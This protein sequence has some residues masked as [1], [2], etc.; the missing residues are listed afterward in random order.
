MSL[1][2][3]RVK[4]VMSD[5]PQA[6]KPLAI[7][8]RRLHT[9]TPVTPQAFVKFGANNYGFV[10]NISESGLVFAP[11]GT[12]TLAV[13]A[14]A[15]MRFQLP[16]SKE[17][18]ETNGEVVWIAESQREAGVHFVDLMD[19][20]RAKIRDW[21][22]QEPV[23]P[24]LPDARDAI[25][26]ALAGSQPST[27][28]AVPEED[29]VLKSIFADPGLFLVGS[30]STRSKHAL[31]QEPIVAEEPPQAPS[32]VS[33]PERRSHPR[34]RVLSLEYLDLG[35][36]NGGIVLNLGEDGMYIQAVASLSPDHISNLSFRIPESDYEIETSGNIVWVGESKKD[37]GI[38]FD[39]L[40]EEARLKIREWVAAEFPSRQD[41]RQSPADSDQFTAKPDS[42][43]RKRDRLVEMPA[44]AKLKS[45][46]HASGTPTVQPADQKP[47]FAPE[48][49]AAELA[50]LSALDAAGISVDYAS[51]KQPDSVASSPTPIVAS[52]VVQKPVDISADSVR[53]KQTDLSEKSSDGSANAVPSVIQK[54]FDV[55]LSA[56]AIQKPST[57]APP[58]AN[59][60]RPG[61]GEKKIVAPAALTSATQ[62]QNS[63]AT[64][65]APLNTPPS[66][67]ANVPARQDDRK[68]ASREESAASSD[69]QN[70]PA[71]KRVPPNVSPDRDAVTGQNN[72]KSA[73]RGISAAASDLANWQDAESPAL[74]VPPDRRDN[75]KGVAQGARKQGAAA[76]G[77]ATRTNSLTPT[78]ESSVV[79]QPR[80]WKSLAAG[81]V[82]I[83]LLSFAAGWIAAGPA[84]RK[85]IFDKFVSRQTD[86]SQSTGNPGSSSAQTD[87]PAPGASLPQSN[88]A[89]APEQTTNPAATQPAPQ[90]P[91]NIATQPISHADTLS[92]TP[93]SQIPH[94]TSVPSQPASQ[95]SPPSAAS[96]GNVASSAPEKS[97]AAKR[98][99]VTSSSTV[100]NATNS[101]K[102]PSVAANNTAT[103]ATPSATNSSLSNAATS[104][105]KSSLAANN[106]APPNTVS[107]ESNATQP[108]S[109]SSSPASSLPSRSSTGQPQPAQL[110]AVPSAPSSPV[111]KSAPP[112]VTTSTT[113]PTP[114]A[115]AEVVKATVSVNAS[116]FPSIRVPPEL[117]SQISKQGASLQIGQLISRVDPT[118][119]EDAQ[120][121][122][123]EG[124]VKLRAIIARD[125]SIQDID[126]M[127]GPPLLVA[128]AANAV[129]Q[130][131]YK[132]TSLDGQPVEATESITVAF[133]LQSVR[134]N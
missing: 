92:P 90:A 71:A 24:D 58:E 104:S 118:Y 87:A 20:T 124:V 60:A 5:H 132:P 47:D 65:P 9:R 63:P 113:S 59:V 117:K 101:P 15:K 13:G 119:P 3:A 78:V 49:P 46:P 34:R 4:E 33:V 45:P 77:I 35:D 30:K 121:Q 102:L 127:S 115:A 48:L 68:S 131:R 22:S 82:V 75:R 134:A 67:A 96:A 1:V 53:S 11:T 12:L 70:R 114:T 129:R 6:E 85:Q 25:R 57:V 91:A 100:P 74:T 56:P 36:S 107:R 72:R 50:S 125:G 55:P 42:D 95:I 38:Q 79:A 18:I 99:F 10:F 94:A 27:S 14:I 37:A 86:S 122:R 120:H 7:G 61:A 2:A 98:D 83:V 106:T 108:S 111:A 51:L 52:P 62:I 97:A 19:D 89:T 26:K 29:K 105:N 54:S 21:I 41:S 93:A 126:Q 123:I 84:G 103:N 44:G 31:Q 69:I 110:T 66:P 28:V 32:A 80:N 88:T 16:D 17:W 128:A 116:P 40:P 8:E 73:A 133:R 23:R 109:I 130:W 112:P 76:G 81:V 43:A 39:N 64:K